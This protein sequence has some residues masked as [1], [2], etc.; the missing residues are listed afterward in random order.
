MGPFEVGGRNRHCIQLRITATV[1]DNHDNRG[2]GRVGL[3]HD[4][5]AALVAI[6]QWTSASTA[7]LR[8]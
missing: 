8:W 1:A 7:K 3:P 5:A 2:N 6:S 4:C